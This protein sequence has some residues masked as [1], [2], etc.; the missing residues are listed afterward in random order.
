MIQRTAVRILRGLEVQKALAG[1]HL[2]KL[3]AIFSN[4]E[5][6]LIPNEFVNA[7]LLLETRTNVVLVPNA[8]IQRNGTSTFVYVIAPNRTVSIRQ[9][10]LG[11]IDAQHSQIASGLQPGEQVVTQGVDRLTE[12]ALVEPRPES[13]GNAPAVAP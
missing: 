11:A 1:E 6:R 8:A 2:L 7:R 3:R 10:K 5:A 9:V 4:G 12:G 13:D